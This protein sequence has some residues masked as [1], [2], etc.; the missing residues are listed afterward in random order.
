MARKA[1][2]KKANVDVL[3]LADIVGFHALWPQQIL[4]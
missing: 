2:K 4:S 3:L 1:K